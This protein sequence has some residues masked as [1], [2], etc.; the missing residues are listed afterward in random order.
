M[1]KKII[2]LLCCVFPAAVFA[3]DDNV[4]TFDSGDVS[5]NG[6]FTTAGNADW[7]DAIS[8]KKTIRFNAGNTINDVG[9]T[10]G[11]ALNL[12]GG[13]FIGYGNVSD[14]DGGLSPSG[15]FYVMGRDS[16]LNFSIKT[17][18]DVSV[19]TQLIVYDGW[20]F[21][22][23]GA[24]NPVGVGMTVGTGGNVA[25]VSVAQNAVLNFVNLD[26]VYINGT[27]T[28]NGGG[29]LNT[30]NV[31]NL[32]VGAIETAGVLNINVNNDVNITSLSVNNTATNTSVSANGNIHVSDFVETV[33]GAANVKLDAVNTIAID[34]NVNNY[35]TGITLANADVTVGGSFNNGI[36]SAVLLQNLKNFKVNGSF[37]NNGMV[38][39]VVTGNSW[40]ANGWNLSGMNPET[41]FNFTTGQLNLG[42]NND[43]LNSLNNMTLNVT[44]GDLTL[45]NVTNQTN[46]AQMLLTATNGTFGAG[47]VLNKG[48]VDL[49]QQ[50]PDVS[51][52]ISAKNVVLGTD[53]TTNTTLETFANANTGIVASEKL[54]V[55]GVVSNQGLTVLRSTNV[56][57]DDILNS[58]LELDVGSLTNEEG[59]VVVNNIT[60]NGGKTLLYAKS[61]DVQGTLY[62]NAGQ[63][64]IDGSDTDGNA[65][66]IGSL[67]VNG[68]TVFV[69]ALAGQ[70]SVDGNVN[71]TGGEL[72][73]QNSVY[74]VAVGGN[75][76]LDGNMLMRAPAF[77]ISAADIDIV[78]GINV[79]LPGRSIKF[80]SDSINVGTDAVVGNVNVIQNSQLVFGDIGSSD[81][82]KVIITGNANINGVLGIYS[83]NMTVNALQN[84]GLIRAYGDGITAEGGDIDISG[85]LRFD[86][87]VTAT[88][89]LGMSLINVDTFTLTT[90]KADSN[91]LLDSVATNADNILYLDSAGGIEISAGLANSGSV[92]A[93][94][95]TNMAVSGLS[96]NSG[97]VSIAADSIQMDDITN[98]TGANMLLSADTGTSVDSI[99]NS[100]VLHISGTDSGIATGALNVTGNITN[101]SGTIDVFA[102][103][104]STQDI[105]IESGAV[106]VY[107]PTSMNVDDVKVTGSVNQG[108]VGDG[109]NIINTPAMTVNSLNISGGD[110]NVGMGSTNYTIV[111]NMLVSG[112]VNVTNGAQAILGVN[113]LNVG[114]INN[115]GTLNVIA[116]N[117]IEVAG[118]INNTHGN[119][120]LSSGNNFIKTNSVNVSDGNV[121]LS[122]AGLTTGSDFVVADVLYQGTDNVMFNVD[123][124]NYTIN[125]SSI[126]VAGIN[127]SGKMTINSSDITIGTNGIVASDLVFSANPVIDWMNISVGQNGV[128]GI[129]GNVDFVGLGSMSVAGDYVF[130]DNSSL[131]ATVL[132]PGMTS[133]NYWASVSM[134]DDDTFGQI[135]DPENAS[136]LISVGGKFMSDI[137]IDNLGT[138]DSGV[139]ED[140]QIG[141]NV[142]DMIDNG[143][144]ILLLRAEDG[145]YDISTKI[146]NVNVKFCNADMT[147]CVPYFNDLADGL[148]AYISVR[149]MLGQDGVSDSLYIVFDNRFGGPVRIFAVQ[150]IVSREE[151][152]LLSEYY[153]AGAMDNLVAGQLINSKFYNESP[154]EVIPSIFENTVFSDVATELY[155]RMEG[156]VMDRDGV[157][158]TN[159]SRLFANYEAEQAVGTMILNEHTYFRSFEDRMFDEFI[160]NRNRRLKKAWTDVDFG[161]FYQNTLDKNHAGG[162]RFSI[163]GGF[164]WQE[165]NT[166]NVGLMGHV[167]HTA[168][169]LSQQVN[170]SYGMVAD[171]GNIE[172]SVSDTNIGFGGYLMKTLGEK[173]RIYGNAVLDAHLFDIQRNQDF[174]DTID[175]SGMAFSLMSEWGL[176]HDILNQYIVG[177]IYARIGYNFGMN[178]DEQVSGSDYMETKQDGYLVFNPGYSVVAQKRIYPSAW[179]Q[180]RPYASVGVEYDVLGVPDSVQYKYGAASNFS[181]Y[182]IDIDPL[183]ANIGGGIEML[184]ANGMQFGLDYR[185]QYNANLQLHNIKLSGS[186]RF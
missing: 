43:L 76:Y 141:I 185:Y 16:N 89:T 48:I 38:E 159:F 136:P 179:F 36:N 120:Y 14:S 174:V 168:S 176:M 164:D 15:A 151:N 62:N 87:D 47:Y 72:D 107:A 163:S 140:A 119:M 50:T 88:D 175:G 133:L 165:S 112:A 147:K 80:V 111:N 49:T 27:S 20:N 170:L 171:W 84:T 125:A 40:F 184:S 52:T 22:V 154:I 114:G 28:V 73:F 32:S 139:L 166:L 93:K 149:D 123:S 98:N 86:S 103:V 161:M 131:M 95:K 71:I 105:T 45:G 12:N 39:A 183:W 116:R 121:V 69:D 124:D 65:L 7:Q 67:Q 83:E 144:A 3:A 100:G 63:T 157:G 102:S 82:S 57:L 6:V 51:L 60:N 143:T 110:F 109:L 126:N 153:G 97:F 25:T 156:Y 101:K 66:Q 108:I 8:N 19:G 41:V 11:T 148:P 10:S 64:V 30:E 118:A 138:P 81:D 42:S 37:V 117:G 61:I 75:L 182:A 96:T 9:S 46:N 90:K 34:G 70:V 59:K 77:T 150:P 53:G 169:D 134:Q 160:W 186:Y 122:G 5:A 135:I 142:F 29:R 21:S 54:I 55:N 104:L 162:N 92:E 172:T 56:E 115:E 4:V 58:G 44:G 145:V 167:S 85:S 94:A 181:E 35:G 155:N 91:I 68:G 13:M 31:N 24:V 106:T 177:N 113:K 33:S 2:S 128:G 18:E 178:I 146:R 23:E 137:N 1:L 74:N 78:Q 152:Y 127:Q 132:K 158:L 129:S 130:D 99:I 173:Y 17:Y 26:D 79:S 180:I